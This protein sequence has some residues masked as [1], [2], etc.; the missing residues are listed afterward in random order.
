[1][2]KTRSSFFLQVRVGRRVKKVVVGELGALILSSLVDP[3]LD[4]RTRANELRAR[5]KAG[6]NVAQAKREESKVSETT[7]RWTC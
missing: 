6:E 5:L 1:M 7:L 2:G 4:A 3:K